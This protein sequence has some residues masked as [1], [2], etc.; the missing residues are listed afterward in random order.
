M[1]NVFTALAPALFS[2]AREIAQEPVGALGSINMNFDDK[3]V[4]IG[5]MVTIPDSPLATEGDYIPA[6][7]TTAGDDKTAE[8]LTVSIDYN[9]DVTWNL[10][11]E[12]MRSLENATS[13]KEWARQM[14]AQGMRTLR[15]GAE[16]R[17]L[18][19]IYKGAS[20]AIGTAGTTPFATSLDEI[21][22]MQK[23]FLDNGAPMADPYLIINTAALN[24]AQKLAIVQ[25]AD[26]AG[27][28]EERRRGILLRQ[29]GFAIKASAG[30]QTHTKGTATGFDCTA[31][32]PVNEVTIACD[33][34]NSGT[35][36]AGDIV[37]RGN[38]GGSTAD[39]N[40]YVV[41]S[42]ST[43]TGAASGNFILSK[44]GVRIATA[45]T[46]EWTIGNS[47]TANVAF[48]RSAV[49]GVMRPPLIPTSPLITQM[50]ISDDRGLTYLLCEIVGDGMKTWRLHL[51]YGFK[52]VNPEFVAILMG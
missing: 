42:G 34:S 6:M 32:E 31:I 8:S 29:W 35:V 14:V 40:K 49:I 1:S 26:K 51:A 18:S 27:S 24:T 15:N 45:I 48:E 3:G 22:D 36:L 25:Q 47:Y 43:L 4:A 38:E 19:V 20:R 10:T 44:P 46:D 28:D 17:L 7:T 13:D 16:G 5:D 21:A 9:K 41:K 30:V 23:I 39:T 52:V 33:G 50:K 11:G 37:T 2:A 12:Q